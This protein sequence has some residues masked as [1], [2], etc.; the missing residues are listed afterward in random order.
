[1][2]DKAEQWWLRW[3]PDVQSLKFRVGLNQFERAN[4]LDAFLRWSET[5][6]REHVRTLTAFEDAPVPL[7]ST[8]RDEWVNQ[9]DGLSLS[10]DGFIPFRD[11][12]D[13]AAKAGVGHLLQPGGSTRDHEVIA[14]CDEYGIWMGFSGLRL[15]YH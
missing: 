7:T 6:D 3:H 10:S 1:V 11:N 4:A 8:Q 2:C 15:F 5:T 9:L 12:I 14:A 13:R